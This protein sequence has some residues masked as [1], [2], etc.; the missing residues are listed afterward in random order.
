MLKSKLFG[1]TGMQENA[2]KIKP[3]VSFYGLKVIANNGSPIDFGRFKGKKVLLV[4]TASDCGFTRQY[5]ELEQ[6]HNRYKDKLVVLGFPANDFKQQEKKDDAAIA[7]FCKVNFGVTFQLMQKSQVVNGPMQNSIF[8]W[9][10]HAEQNGWCNRQ[11]AW[12][13]CKYVVNEE[14]VLTH[15][16]PQT[17]SPLDKEVLAA[18]Q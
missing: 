8:A 17:I 6:L 3:V 2:G 9:L 14:G 11:P 1:R 7:E 4:N 16:F 10:S 15:F 13:F 12:N 18:I 5:E